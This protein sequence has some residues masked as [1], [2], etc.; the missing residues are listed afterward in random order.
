MPRTTLALLAAA[1]LAITPAAAQAPS[2]GN[3]LRVAP[4]TLTRVLDPHFTTSFTTRDFAYLV[5]DTLVAVNDRWEPTPQMLESWERSEDGLNWTFTLRDGLAWHDGSA[6]TAEDCVASL[7]RWGARDALGS[8]MMRAAA[9][10]D[11][12][13]GRTFRLLLREPF[14]LVLEKRSASPVRAPFPCRMTALPTASAR[15]CWKASASASG[16]APFW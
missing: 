8:A 14:G 7:R 10:L 4:E 12:V 1:L 9:S 6:V 11:V 13:D 16:N 5:F 3:T 2:R 15:R